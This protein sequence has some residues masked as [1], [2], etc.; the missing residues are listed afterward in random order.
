M[1]FFQ[2]RLHV[3]YSYEYFLGLCEK[4]P[5][6]S[7]DCNK[8]RKIRNGLLT[9]RIIRSRHIIEPVPAGWEDL[10]LVHDPEY[11][12]KLKDP[13]TLA[14]I[15]F[16][17]Y[18]NPFDTDI[19]EFFMWVTGG[20][21]CTIRQAYDTGNPVFNL[22]GGF[23]HA[24]YDRGEG[25]CPVND[26]A[27][28][29]RR[30]QQDHPEARVLVVDLD[31]HQGNGTGL[32]FSGDPNVFTYSLHRET[33]DSIPSDTNMDVTLPDGTGDGPYMTVLETTLPQVMEIFRPELVV[34]VAGADP[35][36]HD[37]LGTFQLTDTGILTRDRYV[38][39]QC[40]S[41]GIP[42]AVVA[43]GGYGNESW[44]LYFNFIRWAAKGIEDVSHSD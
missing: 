7:F 31:Y 17:D 37:T 35:H 15:L 11:L 36:E 23:H 32:L 14:S 12:E 40:E 18:V 2:P 13:A 19:L 8:F 10:S 41:R 6:S 9:K 44:R 21:I 29:I 22:G 1:K 38:W 25:F 5:R 20:T 42:L 43:G 16:L 39:S 4:G 26:I 28:G 30:L 24:K 3:V 34:Y 33:W 27:V